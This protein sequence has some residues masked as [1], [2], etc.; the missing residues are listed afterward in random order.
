MG[1][2][3]TNRQQRLLL[4]ML[5]IQMTRIVVTLQQFSQALT[6][7]TDW[8]KALGAVTRVWGPA[9]RQNGTSAG[10]KSLINPVHFRL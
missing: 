1:V 10:L 8:S 3:E 4:Q 2:T 7:S 5:G 9:E 6:G